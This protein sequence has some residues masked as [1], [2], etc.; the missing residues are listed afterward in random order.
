[1]AFIDSYAGQEQ[2]PGTWHE[3]KF[4]DKKHDTILE[5]KIRPL[6]AGVGSQLRRKYGK[7]DGNDY[8]VPFSKLTEFSIAMACE[9]WVD[10]RGLYVGIKNEKAIAIY[11][12][13]LGREV[14]LDEEVCLDGHLTKRLKQ[15]V[16][17][18]HVGL[19][20][21]INSTSTSLEAEATEEEV[22]YEEHL[23]GNSS[24]S[25][26][27]SSDQTTSQKSAVE[28]VSFEEAEKNPASQTARS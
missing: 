21:Y 4:Y 24:A 9:S 28:P 20:G 11:S 7:K 26:S 14:E 3:T 13:E 12:K 8:N 23:E 27:S 10:S 16:L 19:L 17:A 15:D 18:A 2:D 25:S 22:D 5:L 6:P 1:M